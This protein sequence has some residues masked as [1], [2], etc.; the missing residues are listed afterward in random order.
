MNATSSSYS[1]FIWF[2]C[3]HPPL[4]SSVKTFLSLFPA[5]C[6]TLVGESLFPDGTLDATHLLPHIPKSVALPG[7]AASVAEPQKAHGPILRPEDATDAAAAMPAPAARPAGRGGPQHRPLAKRHVEED[8]EYEWRR[9]E[10]EMDHYKD[11]KRHRKL[12]KEE[13]A[14]CSRKCREHQRNELGH[15]I[16]HVA[17]N[18][19]KT[20]L[21]SALGVTAFVCILYWGS[22]G[23][24]WTMGTSRWSRGVAYITGRRI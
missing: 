18:T 4:V 23:P 16:G 9:F 2:K 20:L 15:Q 10:R 22:W 11:I 17:K 21:Y 13:Q 19:G 5:V 6:A 7:G 12:T 1:I 8:R 14:A 3:V 24:R